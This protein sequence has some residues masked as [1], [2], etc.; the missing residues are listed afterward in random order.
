MTTIRAFWGYELQATVHTFATDAEA[1][2]FCAGV[3]ACDGWSRNYLTDGKDQM[4]IAQQRI[5]EGWENTWHTDDEPSIYDS[6]EAAEW[7]LDDLLISTKAA[8]ERGD[9]TDAYRREDYRII[10]IDLEN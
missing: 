1:T 3:E 9:M 2:A 6:Y 10:P 5:G 8:A 4:W 7:Q